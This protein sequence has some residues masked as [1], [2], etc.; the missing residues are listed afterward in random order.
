MEVRNKQQR[1]KVSERKGH[2]YFPFAAHCK[3]STRYWRCYPSYLI[4][5][6][7]VYDIIASF[8]AVTCSYKGVILEGKFDQCYLYAN[9]Q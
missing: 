5:L 1:G 2:K 3:N 7:T 8:F 9:N 6:N 4:Y